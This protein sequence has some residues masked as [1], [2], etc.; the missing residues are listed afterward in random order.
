MGAL[1]PSMARSSVVQARNMSAAGTESDAEFDARYIAYFDR[2]DIDGWE[3]RK[4]MADLVAMDLV[5]EPTI[6]AA[7]LRA[8][9]RVNDYSLTTRILEV[10]RMKCM[11]NMQELW[12]YMM[13]ELKPTLDELG[14]SSLE[15]MGYDTPEL[16]LPNPYEVHGDNKHPVLHENVTNHNEG[17]K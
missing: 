4:G 10:V 13:Q 14:I 16:A 3:I 12:P 7:A 11:P 6:A 5:P 1:K 17:F 8:C 2:K 15:E 9:R